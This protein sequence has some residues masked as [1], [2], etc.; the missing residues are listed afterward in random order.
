MRRHLALAALPLMILLV[1]ASADASPAGADMVQKM[2]CYNCHLGGAGNTALRK[3]LPPLT[4]LG[5]RYQARFLYDYIASPTSRRPTIAPARMPTFPM[6]DEERLALVAHLEAI[7]TTLQSGPTFPALAAGGD[8]AKGEA[9]VKGALGCIGC[10]SIEGN[11]GQTAPPLDGAGDRLKTDWLARYLVDPPR[12]A[13]ATPMPALF[14]T[15]TDTGYV[16]LSAEAPEQLA[17]VM[18]Y[19]GTLR[20]SRPSKYTAAR[21]KTPNQAAQMG[22]ALVTGF[23]CGACHNDGGPM[24]ENAPD[25]ALAGRRALPQ[26]LATY[27]AAPSPIRPYGRQPHSGGRM[28]NYRLSPD[29]VQ[30]IAGHLSKTPQKPY[31]ATSRGA[32]TL[33]PF[34]REKARRFL[35]EKLSCLGCHQLDGEGGRVGP[36]LSDVALR[37]P[38]AYIYSMIHAPQATEPGTI[39]PQ[40]RGRP[41]AKTMELVFAY[42]TERKTAGVEHTYLSPLD[43]PPNHLPA[44]ASKVARDYASYCAACHGSSGAGNGFNAPFLPTK[45]TNHTDAKYLSTRP[46]DTLF[47]GVH[48]GGFVLDKSHRMPPWGDT[49]SRAQIR[50]LV[51]HLRTLCQCTEPAWA[52]DNAR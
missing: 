49:L 40:E 37:R 43:A 45:P 2:G 33:S 36:N 10:H 6:S 34:K 30:Q 12:M 39:M 47:D 21:A 27:L 11:G 51:G 28:P 1:S 46:D 15:R 4:D 52:R 9:L 48:V 42:L 41:T 25:L 7:P 3:A 24:K 13:A 18:A 38:P 14:Y 29:E 26:W 16:P 31:P 19:L 8:P 32:M 23:N 17:A 5:S 50:A 22:S 44:N 20:A 35:V